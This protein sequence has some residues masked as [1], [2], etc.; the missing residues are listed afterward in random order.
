MAKLGLTM[1]LSHYD[2][3][4]ALMEKKPAVEDLFAPATLNT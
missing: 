4:Q 2:R 3:D 1:A